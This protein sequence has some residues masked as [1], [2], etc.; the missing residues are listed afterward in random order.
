MVLEQTNS[1]LKKLPNNFDISTVEV[2]QILNNVDDACGYGGGDPNDDD[3]D[4]FLNVNSS[5]IRNLTNSR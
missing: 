3:D 5:S 1:M 2:S 4:I